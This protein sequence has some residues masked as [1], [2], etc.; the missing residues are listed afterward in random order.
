MFCTGAE[1]RKEHILRIF[2]N[3]VLRRSFG[4][5]E[6]EMTGGYRGLHNVAC[7]GAIGNA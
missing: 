5:K 2:E 6:E 3:M 7:K 1:L 4:L